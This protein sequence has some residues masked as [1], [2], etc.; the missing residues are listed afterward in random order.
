MLPLPHLTHDKPDTRAKM[1]IHS[2]C[3]CVT[4][5][6]VSLSL[7]PLPHPRGCPCQPV[8]FSTLAD[9]SYKAVDVKTTPNPVL[10]GLANIR[11]ALPTLRHAMRALNAERD[12]GAPLGIPALPDSN[13]EL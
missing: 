9:G 3:P 10:A 1:G 4:T 5:L 7:A 12:P 11:E 13:F 8:V 6:P 2:T